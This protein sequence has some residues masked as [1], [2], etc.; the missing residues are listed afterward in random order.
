MIGNRQKREQQQQQQQQVLKHT[1]NK[2]LIG[3]ISGHSSVSGVNLNV[4]SFHKAVSA[5]FLEPV[6]GKCF[7]RNF[8]ENAAVRLFRFFRKDLCA[9]LHFF[10]LNF[11]FSLAIYGT[12]ANILHFKR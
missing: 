9:P 4:L 6:L 8:H 2:Y 11:V 3:G 10:S 12:S 1:T 7:A 5:K